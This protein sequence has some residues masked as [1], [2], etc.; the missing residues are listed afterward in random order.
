MGVT[1]ALLAQPWAMQ[2]VVRP[3]LLSTS[4]IGFFVAPEVGSL[5]VPAHVTVPEVGRQSLPVS[6][7]PAA[8]EV[9]S[10]PVPAYVAVPEL[11]LIHI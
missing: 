4:G 3:Q 7:F 8:P 9:G 6:A 1:A 2:G 5:P 10:L 11:S